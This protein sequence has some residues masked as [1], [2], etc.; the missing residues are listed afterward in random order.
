MGATQWIKEKITTSK[1]QLWSGVFAIFSYIIFFPN[2]S[3]GKS[4]TEIINIPLLH[5]I[6][7]IFFT[8]KIHEVKCCQFLKRAHYSIIDVIYLRVLN[9]KSTLSYLNFS[10]VVI[11][12]HIPLRGL[13]SNFMSNFSHKPPP[14]LK[15]N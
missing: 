12:S 6:W 11:S 9:L 15:L 5:K 10:S 13:Y 2:Y 7:R 4:K 1:Q 14:W 3:H 8:L